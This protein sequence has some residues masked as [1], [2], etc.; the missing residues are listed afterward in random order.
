MLVELKNLNKNYHNG[1]LDVPALKNINL[2]IEKGEF[3]VLAGPSGSGKTTLLNIIGTMDKIS[4]GLAIVDGI[5]LSN[6]T[7]NEASDFR[8]DKIGF[9][10]QSYNLIPVLTVYE[11]VEFIL[12]LFEKISDKEK[13][14]K[15]NS[16]LEELGLLEY[17]NRTPKELSGGQQ[18]R[19][20]IARALIKEPLIVL[21]DE[22]TA[23]LD[24]K[25]GES[26]LDLMK[27]LNEKKG[28]TFIFS[29]HDNKIIERGKRVVYLRDG[30]I[31]REEF[32]NDR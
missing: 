17:K 1:I 32:Q 14:I 30:E 24:S 8:R 31:V 21:A 12:D 28:V 22:P 16:L 6:L 10:F 23:N 26:I 19:V 29:S 25:T 9:I 4:S 15:I 5:E 3:T 18:Q 13:K 27:E 20:A 2:K 11:N 7:K